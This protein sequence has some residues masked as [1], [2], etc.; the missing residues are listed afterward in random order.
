MLVTVT[1]FVVLVK[2]VGSSSIPTESKT[3]LPDRLKNFEIIEHI[4]CPYVLR[5]GI[6][7]T[8][9]DV[10]KQCDDFERA[11]AIKTLKKDTAEDFLCMV[12]YSSFKKTCLMSA[13]LTKMI[14]VE[15]FKRNSALL[16]QNLSSICGSLKGLSNFSRLMKEVFDN[17]V[18]EKC[19]RLC[20]DY[21][22]NVESLCVYSAGLLHLVEN[23]KNVGGDVVDQMEKSK[24]KYDMEQNHGVI[25]NQEKQKLSE[26]SKLIRSQELKE[27]NNVIANLSRNQNSSGDR[28]PIEIQNFTEIK[29]RNQKTP[30]Q[31]IVTKV[32]ETIT[33]NSIKNAQNTKTLENSKQEEISKNHVIPIEYE[34]SKVM[35]D[36]KMSSTPSKSQDPRTLVFSTKSEISKP[37][38]TRPIDNT[39]QQTNPDFD[40]DSPDYGIAKQTPDEVNDKNVESLM[41]KNEF[42]DYNEQGKGAVQVP[43]RKSKPDTLNEDVN[44]PNYLADDSEGD[45][46]FFSYF[47]TVCVVFVLGYVG[48]HNKQK[49]FTA[50]ALLK[51][52]LINLICFFR[53]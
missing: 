21:A 35:K 15:E 40:F 9:L 1:V 44:A 14:N 30:K 41:V 47:M 8:H 42:E 34:S 18:S 22:G 37:K 36:V 53:F 38:F 52:H 26:T 46:Y 10:L 7:D 13:S 24:K 43:V 2:I 6:L 33:S 50:R 29:D 28:N 20:Q 23:E 4:K 12:Y 48:Y 3:N 19:S 39:P 16:A 32:Y 49:V 17:D 31:E 11:A 25:P 27:N 51:F 5:S 45:S